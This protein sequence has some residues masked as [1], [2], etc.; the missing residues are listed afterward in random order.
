MSAP[1]PERAAAWAL[2]RTAPCF[3][4]ALLLQ[5]ADLHTWG[6][7]H[8]EPV[9]QAILHFLA[10]L[11][12]DDEARALGFTSDHITALRF[13]LVALLAECAADQSGSDR[14]RDLLAERSDL[15]RSANVGQEFFIALEQRLALPAPTPADLAV[16]QIHALCLLLGLRGRYG[17]DI[18][19]TESD[20]QH[21]LRRLQL[22]LRPLLAPR[23]PPADLPVP[24]DMP[25]KPSRIPPLIAALLLVF[26]AALIATLRNDLRARAEALE[27]HLETHRP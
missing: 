22:R 18:A 24:L 11:R 27:S 6:D 4:H 1:G 21:Q 14:W 23:P 13:A 3:H 12:I 20:L 2:R 25:Q 7:P 26:T 10:E 17:A 9:L 19:A 5:R 16:L 15:P 8:A